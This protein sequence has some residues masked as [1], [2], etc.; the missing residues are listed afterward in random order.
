[1][2]PRIEILRVGEEFSW[3]RFF[4]DRNQRVKPAK[5][6]NSSVA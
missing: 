4:A 3:L 2:S 6:K 1:M 5:K